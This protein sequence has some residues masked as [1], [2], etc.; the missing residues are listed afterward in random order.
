MA[1][2]SCTQQLLKHSKK[3]S[4]SMTNLESKGAQQLPC[5]YSQPQPG[6]SNERIKLTVRNT[7]FSIKLSV[8]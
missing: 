8:S 2:I 4:L 3:R 6:G 5:E 7:A 1:N